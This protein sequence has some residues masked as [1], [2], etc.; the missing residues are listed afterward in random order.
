MAKLPKEEA[1]KKITE[2]DG[3]FHVFA[4]EEYDTFLNNLKDTE[5]FKEQID[6][7][8]SEI[9]KQ[10]D[11]D[12][13]AATGKR[14]GQDEKTYHFIKKEVKAMNDQLDELAK[15]KEELEKAVK[16]NTGNETIEMLRGELDSM[17]AKHQKYK[18]DAEN[19]YQE[20][21]QTGTKMRI[22]HE[23]DKSMTGIKFK[24]TKIIPE[25][26]RNAMINNA[27]NELAERASFI[28][29]KL[30]FL[31]AEGKVMRDGDLNVVTP[32]TALQE[33]L[34]SIIDEGRKAKG[35]DIV[36]PDVKKTDGKVEVN[37]S[38]PDT[39]KTNVQLTEYL[40]DVGLVKDSDEY[41]AA[42]AKYR[43]NVETA[44]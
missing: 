26:V 16:D 32:Q 11:D 1:I 28:D 41:R 38:L 7:R 44:T 12:F 40:L 6:S 39:V 42:Y 33:K 8:V 4:Q 15:K 35:V 25:D 27:K 10:Y 24:D 34:K 20:L 29:G 14:R 43:D 13:F 17:K 18:E 36:E 3:D 37:L 22:Q 9:H 31:D 30:V 2:G 19:R 23:F 5:V 21:E